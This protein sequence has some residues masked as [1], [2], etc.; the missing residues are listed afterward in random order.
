MTLN[1][2]FQ[3]RKRKSDE[4]SPSL[5]T[6]PKKIPESFISNPDEIA[7]VLATSGTKNIETQ[8]S[9]SLALTAAKDHDEFTLR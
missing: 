5:A 2:L 1:F 6:P 3:Q 7:Q 8:A 4:M 9:T